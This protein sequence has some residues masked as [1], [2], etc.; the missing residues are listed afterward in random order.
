[1][2]I[3]INKKMQTDSQPQQLPQISLG[4]LSP[5]KYTWISQIIITN[6]ELE[7]YSEKAVISCIFLLCPL[8]FLSIYNMEYIMD[9]LMRCFEERGAE[10][11]YFMINDMI[12][13]QISCQLTPSWLMGLRFPHL[14]LH[15]CV[16]S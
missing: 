2:L 10:S 12:W 5:C 4:F 14:E 7:I 6:G 8:S 9:H 11:K 1:M 15:V 3:S 16:I 13:N